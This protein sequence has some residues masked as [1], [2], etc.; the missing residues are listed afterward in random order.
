MERHG[1]QQFIVLEVVALNAL[2]I[3]KDTD[4][5]QNTLILQ[6][7]TTIVAFMD[8]NPWLSTSAIKRGYK[9][10]LRISSSFIDLL[11][12]PNQN[13]NVQERC[14]PRSPS[15]SS[16]HTISSK[17]RQVVPRQLVLCADWSG[18]SC[19]AIKFTLTKLVRCLT[20]R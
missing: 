19:D 15:L 8:S 14:T 17:V 16:T 18:D 1:L 2:P 20:P 11:R 4:V 6:L 5:T 7:I 13:N 10:L 9:K 3:S 12:Y